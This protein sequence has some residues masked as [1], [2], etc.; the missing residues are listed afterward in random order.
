MQVSNPVGVLEN[1]RYSSLLAAEEKNLIYNEKMYWV[2]PALN[3]ALII[4]N[5]SSFCT[6]LAAGDCSGMIRRAL[7]S[8]HKS[9]CCLW[10]SF[11][12][13]PP[14]VLNR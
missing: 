2:F 5:V 14:G 4:P 3:A 13:E 7:D 11:T 10:K 1:L 9:S 6:F 8:V 12:L